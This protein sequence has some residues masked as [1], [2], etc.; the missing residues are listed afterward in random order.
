MTK[1]PPEVR[2]CEWETRDFQG[3]VLTPRDRALCGRFSDQQLSIIETRD[4]LRVETRAHVG[5]LQLESVRVCIEPRLVG[6][7]T[8]LVRMIEYTRA[9]ELMRRVDRD[10]GLGTGGEDLFDLLVMLFARACQEILNVGVVSDYVEQHEDLAV[11]R[12]RLDIRAQVLRRWGQVD[13]LVCDFEERVRDVPENRWVLR[14][15]RVARIGVRRP[16]LLTNVSRLQATWEEFCDDDPTVECE[17]P[18]LTRVNGHYSQA[19]ELAYLL[20][21]G[22]GVSDILRFGRANHLRSS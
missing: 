15:L 6:G 13:R 8:N 4:G 9:V 7:P 14:A 1:T 5:V 16:D 21:D 3:I 12:G 19:L 11:L 17:R 10:A 20:A 22:L 18:V 2:L